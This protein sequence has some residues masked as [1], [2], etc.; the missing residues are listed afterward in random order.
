MSS[1]RRLGL[2]IIGA[3]EV[4]QV[5]H[6][7]CLLLLSHLFKIESIC[8][9]SL[10]TVEH[11]ATK[12]NVPHKTTT[13]QAVIDNPNVEAVFILTS[14]ES[15]AP[16]AISSLNAGKHVFVEKPV[17]LS[18]ASIQSIIDAEENAPGGARVFVGYMRRYAPSFLQ[19]FKREIATIPKILYA[20]VR[21]FSGPNAQFVN[22]SGT[23]QVKNTDYPAGAAEERNARLEALYAEA[24]P[25]QDITD[26]K[27]KFCRFLGSLG[28]H[29]ISLM[30]E[31]LGFPEKV[32]G[33]SAHDP[34]YSAIMTFR[35]QDGSTYSTTYESGIDGVPVFDAHVTVYG[36]NKRVTIKAC[37]FLPMTF[38]PY[39]K[40]LPIYVEVEEPNEHGEIQRRTMLSSYEDAYTAELQEMYEVFVN[41]KAIKSTVQDAKKDLEIY[42]MMYRCWSGN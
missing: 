38:P 37:V 35:N 20:R 34:F 24:F 42:D 1:P 26:E 13:P 4:F 7:P 9:L 25:N 23:F 8:D 11:C 14:D 10:K 31:V 27:R 39:V 5:C 29:D 40:G 16:L 18:L 15:H 3:G 30:R 17:S 36:A 12:F 33:V 6:G 41:G 21:D 28:S 2:G 19:A 32:V 22:Q